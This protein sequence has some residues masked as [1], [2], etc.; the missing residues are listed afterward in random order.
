MRIANQQLTR[1]RK[2]FHKA[3]SGT[4]KLNGT[5]SGN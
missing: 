1:K 2:M 3:D 5:T 4:L